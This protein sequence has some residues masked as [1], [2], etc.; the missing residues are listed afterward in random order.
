MV[1]RSYL[2][3]IYQFEQHLK[4]KTDGNYYLTLS[5][6]KGARVSRSLMPN[7]TVPVRTLSNL[8]MWCCSN[9]KAFLLFLAVCRTFLVVNEGMEA[10][11]VYYRY[12]VSAVRA[13]LACLRLSTSIAHRSVLWNYSEVLNTVH[14]GR[15][16]VRWQQFVS[17]TLESRGWKIESMNESSMNLKHASRSSGNKLWEIP[18]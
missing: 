5:E 14:T 7:W 18:T 11:D 9:L 10:A 6:S 16:F 4:W 1:T 3:R 12:Q 13:C 8:S 15:N 2:R 17:G